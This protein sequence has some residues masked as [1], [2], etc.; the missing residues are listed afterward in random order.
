MKPT[1]I[2]TT[3]LAALLAG[4]LPAQTTPRADLLFERARQKENVQGDLKGAIDIYRQVVARHGKDR[5]VAARAILLMAQCYE[6]LGQTEARKLYE[7]LTRNYADQPEAASQ[8]RTRLAALGV[9]A[10]GG[11]ETRARL[12]WDQAIDYWG[13]VSADGRLLSF[14]DWSTGD[15]AVRDLRAGTHRRVTNMGGYEKSQGEAEAS[16]ISPDGKRIVFNWHR[17]DP[18]SKSE[19]AYQLRIINT[20]GTGER[21]LRTSGTQSYMEAHSWSPDG[22]WM[23]VVVVEG[24]NSRIELIPADTGEARVIRTRSTLRKTNVF[25]SPDGQWLAYQEVPRPSSNSD[26]S[27]MLIP[28]GGS[29]GEEVQVARDSR[30]AGWTP[31]GRALLVA[32]EEGFTW[33]LFLQPVSQG[34]PA[35]EATPVHAPGISSFGDFLGITAKGELYYGTNNNRIEGWMVRTGGNPARWSEPESRFEIA[36]IGYAIGAG[37]LRFSPDGKQLAAFVPAHSIMIRNV[38]GGRQR[39]ITPQLKDHRRFEWMPDGQS[40]LVSATGEQGRFGLHRVDVQT[41]AATYVCGLKSDAREGQAFAPSADGLRVYHLTAQGLTSID[42][43][44]CSETALPTRDFTSQGQQNIKLSRDGRQLLL[45]SGQYIGIYDIASGSLREL[46]RRQGE[47]GSIVW[48]SDWSADGRSIIAAARSGMQG[49]PRELWVFPVEGGAPQV[50]ALPG[51]FRNL[52]VSAD[53]DHLAA[54]HYDSHSQ[55]WVLENFLPAAR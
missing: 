31:D 3:I 45:T 52:S 53:G 22:K 40:F 42:L 14:I 44:G 12:V 32:R 30:L 41:G 13:C 24:G 16:C 54:M 37:N 5:A 49:G 20:D 17:W 46:H 2:L 19:G 26:G 27:I 35:G 25:F 23:A 48:G 1:T 33:K 7:D 47:T 4:P 10:P 11:T 15:L 18:A 6:K 55:V 21:I 29:S 28:A 50:T 38:A 34:K 9:S 51:T 39:A 43:S 36:P 8:A